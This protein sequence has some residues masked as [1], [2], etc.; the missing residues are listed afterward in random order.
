MPVYVDLP[1]K[2][3][4]DKAKKEWINRKPQSE[5]TVIGRVHTVNPLAGENFYL[6]ILLH[7]EH[8]RGKVSFQDLKVLG[9]GRV[10]ETYKE[11]CRELGFLKDDLE[12]ERVLEES[13]FTKLCPQI[14]E[15]F[16]VILTFCQ[17]ANPRALFDTFWSTWTD[18]FKRKGGKKDE[19]E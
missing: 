17:P 2:F 6:R 1:K 15:L 18:D 9:N 7:N 14:R 19:V 12:W 8:C 3:R 4:Y 16:V 13:A 10:C 5:D 11:V